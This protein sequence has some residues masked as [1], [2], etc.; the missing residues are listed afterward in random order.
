MNPKPVTR[1]YQVRVPGRSEWARIWITDDGC[2]TTISDHGNY[3]Y[4]F[5]APG[6][7]FRKF[8][9]GCGDDYILNKLSEGKREVNHDLTVAALRK[10]FW[11]LMGDGDIDKSQADQEEEHLEGVDFSNGEARGIWFSNTGLDAMTASECMV[12]EYPM[13]LRMFVKVLWPLFIE[14]LKA[15]LAAEAA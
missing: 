9:T 13:Q 2:I 1:F 14:Q 15:E 4:W 3:G 12:R 10:K 11:A 8:L 5:G 6:C 7:E